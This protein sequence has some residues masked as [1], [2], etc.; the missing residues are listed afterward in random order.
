MEL[1]RLGMLSGMKWR[2]R[3]GGGRIEDRRGAGGLGGAFPLPLGKAGGGGI[4][5]IILL[6]IYLLVG[7][8]PGGGGGLGV[9][10]GTGA[11]P[12]APEPTEAE[13]Q[14]APADDPGKFVDFVAGDVDATWKKIFAASGKTYQQPIIVLYD[15]QVSS[16]CGNAPATVG[17]FYCPN[18]RKVYLDLPFMEQ[19]QQRLGAQGDFAQAY[20]VAHEIGHHVQN[21]LGVMEDVNLAQQESPDDAND[22]SVRLELQA[23]CL[24]GIWAHSAVSQA[25][26][27]ETGDL[28]EALNAA[29]A[30]GDDRI[31]KQSGGGVNPDTFTHGSGEQRVT[32]FRNGFESGDPTACDTFKGDV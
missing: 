5:A 9:D 23:D 13:L 32:W 12:G 21:L 2:G 4:G 22:L 27:L 28:E 10:P 29:A 30:V 24:A 3:G 14:Q 6:V 20:I 8:L 26:L 7:G 11:L 18:D 1:V 15:D 31:Q 17:P 25:D 19:L 16:A